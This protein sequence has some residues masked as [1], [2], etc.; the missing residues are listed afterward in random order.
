MRSKSLALSTFIIGICVAFL[1]IYIFG[2]SHSNIGYVDSSKLL[3]G[4]K[5][6]VEARKELEKKQT[7][8][9]GNIDSLAKD[10]QDAIKK[11]E[12]TVATGTD[13][14]KS[15]TKELISSKQKELFDYQNAIKLNAG[16]E[17]QRLTQSVYSTINAYLLR[18]GKSKGYKL[19]LIAANGNIAYGD[20][21][22]DITD[23]VVED[24][25]KEY[26]VSIK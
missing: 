5:S 22:L 16:Q 7:V 4:Y 21:S 3:V 26:A 10:V 2:F 24:L 18:Y 15:L 8:W 13:K 9:Q 23:K 12:K 1:F 17:E 20:P 11:Y 6:M 14:E 25:N 19:I